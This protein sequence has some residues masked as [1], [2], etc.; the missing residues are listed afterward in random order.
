MN[1]WSGLL[2]EG[3]RNGDE[4]HALLSNRLM[5]RTFKSH[6]GDEYGEYGYHWEIHQANPLIFG[7]AG[8]D[9]TQGMAIPSEDLIILFFTQSRG[10]EMRN[11]WK[12]L[13]LDTTTSQ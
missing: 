2:K 11:R 9:G 10:H 12:R 13:A 3:G 6:G 5:E 1:Y 4:Q 8:S 7:H